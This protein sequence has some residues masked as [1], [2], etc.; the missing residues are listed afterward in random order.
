MLARSP[1]RLPYFS[2][3]VTSTLTR[4]G[5]GTGVGGGEGHSEGNGLTT[6]ASLGFHSS[7]YPVAVVP[8]P[9]TPSS[10]SELALTSGAGTNL[11]E[12]E[13]WQGAWSLECSPVGVLEESQWSQLGPSWISSCQ[14]AI[15]HSGEHQPNPEEPTSRT[16]P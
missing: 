15:G 14:L 16:Q 4:W 8:A 12:G 7:L 11:L 6:L 5:A 10:V 9:L 2:Y 3:G 13:A 1:A